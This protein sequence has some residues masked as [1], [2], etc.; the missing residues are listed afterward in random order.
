[1]NY[2]DLPLFSPALASVLG[3]GEI[4]STHCITTMN[5]IVLA[6]FDCYLKDAGMFSV[7]ECYE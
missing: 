5:E 1:M 3:A 6:F 7:Q 2:T 4:D